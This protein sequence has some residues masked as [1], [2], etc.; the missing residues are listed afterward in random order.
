MRHLT[1]CLLA[2]LL[3]MTAFA[4]AATEPASPARL[5]EVAERG[6]HVMPFDL[7]KTTHVFSKTN[8]GGRQEV[9]VK[10]AKE[11]GQIRLIREHLS[12]IAAKFAK[13]DFSG[14]A[15][16]HGED[17]PGLAELKAARPGQVKFAYRE[18]PK[19]ARI[20]YSTKDRVL[21]DAIHSYFDAQLRD[22]ARHAS[23]WGAH[24][25]MH[26]Q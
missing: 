13:G 15:Q 17:M 2:L 12:A 4:V 5:G 21:V 26:G 24:S 18:L 11:K 16:I 23:M 9:L 3:S 7:E 20:D 10:D 1:T 19:G 25:H 22:H 14:P 8:D 6:M